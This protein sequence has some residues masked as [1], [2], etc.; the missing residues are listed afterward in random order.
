MKLR[1]YFIL[2]PLFAFNFVCSNAYSNSIT[3]ESQRKFEARL[4][5]T[6]KGIYSYGKTTYFVVDKDVSAYLEQSKPLALWTA[7]TLNFVNYILKASGNISNGYPW[8]ETLREVFIDKA[9]NI[10]LKKAGTFRTQTRL[11]HSLPLQG[12]IVWAFSSNYLKSAIAELNN[13]DWGNVRS[14]TFLDMTAKRK[15]RPHL[16]KLYEE[17]DNAL[18]AFR[19]YLEQAPQDLEKV[20]A[21]PDYGK[22]PVIAALLVIKNLKSGG[23]FSDVTDNKLHDPRYGVFKCIAKLRHLRLSAAAKCVKRLNTDKGLSPHF[24]NFAKLAFRISA[25][26]DLFAIQPQISETGAHALRYVL[27]TGGGIYF[28]NTYSNSLN[29]Y[30]KDAALLYKNNNTPHYRKFIELLLKSVAQSPRHSETWSYLGKYFLAKGKPYEAAACL[31]QAIFLDPNLLAA[32]HTLAIVYGKLGN[33][34]QARNQ[35]RSL[36]DRRYLKGVR[37]EGLRFLEIERTL[38]KKLEAK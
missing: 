21:Y 30:F 8:G 32:R 24:N 12:K 20:N 38:T 15:H 10:R 31:R 7:A 11:V 35:L 18:D 2:L 34:L 1:R 28:S 22:D 9:A 27:K 16:K 6:K 4:A 33:K 29:N 14:R 23:V 26:V 17:E 36:L 13:T 37:V 25:N 5:D 19:L 3:D